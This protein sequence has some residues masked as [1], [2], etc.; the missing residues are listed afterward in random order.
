MNFFYFKSSHCYLKISSSPSNLYLN[1]LTNLMKMSLVSKNDVENFEIEIKFLEHEPNYVRRIVDEMPISKIQI[2]ATEQRR[3]SIMNIL[4]IVP[5]Y[6]ISGDGVSYDFKEKSIGIRIGE[7]RIPLLTEEKTDFTKFDYKSISVDTNYL[8]GLGSELT[9]TPFDKIILSLTLRISTKSKLKYANIAKDKC[10]GIF[11]TGY[12][13]TGISLV[14]SEGSF[15]T[16]FNSNEKDG[17]LR[18]NYETD[19]SLE[20][21]IHIDQLLERTLS[22]V[23]DISLK[24]RG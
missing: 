4:E 6:T 5:R 19:L 10:P 7:P 11:D 21:P 18:I 23:N 24:I 3:H 16:R 15:I 20:G 2:K 22:E 9:N 12:K 13:L 8:M 14:K 17:E 1:I